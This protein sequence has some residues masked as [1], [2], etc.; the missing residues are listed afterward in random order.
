MTAPSSLPTDREIEEAK[1]RLTKF[2]RLLPTHYPSTAM[3][4]TYGSNIFRRDDSLCADILMIINIIEVRTTERN[5]YAQAARNDLM[6]DIGPDGILSRLSSV[7]GELL[8]KQAAI[9]SIY[10]EY[11]RD[12]ECD[13]VKLGE[14][15]EAAM[16]IATASPASLPT[17]TP[18]E[19]ES[20][21]S[22]VRALEKVTERLDFVLNWTES[23]TGAVFPTADEAVEQASQVMAQIKGGQAR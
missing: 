12:E 9:Q 14:K 5:A 10:D 2:A 19:L 1:G 23:N 13:F 11:M 8:G 17:R 3:N 16:S 21:L 15:I 6:R 18:E 4:V 22:A 7:E 20:L